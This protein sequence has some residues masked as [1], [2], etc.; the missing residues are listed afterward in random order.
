MWTPILASVFFE[1]LIAT[2]TVSGSLVE[3]DFA[4]TVA[5]VSSDIIDLRVGGLV[6]VHA[7][8]MA[9]EDSLVE[10]GDLATEAGFRLRRARIGISGQFGGHIGVYLAANLLSADEDV[11]SVSDATLSYVFA[12]WFGV[13]A[14]LGKL[15]FSRSALDS[16][17]NLLS[18]ERPLAVRRIVPSRRLGITAEGRLFSDRLAYLLSV[19]NASEGFALGNRFGGFLYGA[20]LIGS[21]WGL[22][23]VNDRDSRFR[24]SLAVAG[25][26]EDG[27]STRTVAATAD[28]L[29]T[30][31]GASLQVE[32][33]CDRRTPED[34][35][36]VSPELADTIERCGAYAE[37][38]YAFG[39][40]SVPLR[41]VAR[42]ELFDDD[43]AVSDSGD[44]ILVSGGLNADVYQP[45]LRAQL[46]Y[47]ARVERHGA[48]LEN[49]SLVAVLQGSF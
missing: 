41:V 39:V 22:A 10:N 36:D 23:N 37:V 15:P 3:P 12:D 40:W 42:G 16:S 30:W 17:R 45:Y 8:A 47:Q 13:T 2:A 5:V 49:D 28:L 19:R 4:P 6:Q 34:A 32:A 35:P 24:L 27:P 7:A 1:L 20:R 14:G 43:R 25:L 26:Y 18:I 44:V 9:G 48:T 46:H 29:T 21:P 38:G 31:Y 11:G 33:L